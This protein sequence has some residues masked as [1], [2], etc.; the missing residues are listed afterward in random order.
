M[1]RRMRNRGFG[2]KEIGVL[3]VT[4]LVFLAIILPLLRVTAGKKA[5]SNE[6]K[7][8]RQIFMGL[9]SYEQDQSGVPAPNLVSARRY[10]FDD[11][12]LTSSNDPY[13]ESKVAPVDAG[14]PDGERTAQVRVSDTYIWAY[15]LGKPN[16]PRSTVDQRIG[17]IAN[18]WQGSVSAEGDFKA[19]VSGKVHRV[20]M[21][22]SFQSIDLPSRHLG[23]AQRLFSWN[24]Q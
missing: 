24:G 20:M 12:L 23:E 13:R 5:T 11:R 2:R 15:F 8:M 3:A 21:D 16:A 19:T 14:L 6:I 4:V 9:T 7:R 10:V 1:V 17:L 22:G 18:E